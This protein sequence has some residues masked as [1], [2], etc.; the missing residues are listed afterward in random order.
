MEE[1]K[2][3]VCPACWQLFSVGQIHDAG[4]DECRKCHRGKCVE[5]ATP[6]IPSPPIGAELL[7]LVCASYKPWGIFDSSTGAS[8][9]AECRDTSRRVFSPL[10]MILNCP[11]CG[12]RHV[13][14]PEPENDWTNPPHKSHLCH[15]CGAVWRPADVPTYGVERIDTRGGRDTWPPEAT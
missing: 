10:P 7:C 14:Y 11:K 8:V 15:A 12:V 1:T 9:C 6:I 5:V 2:F 3:F 13:D 4:D